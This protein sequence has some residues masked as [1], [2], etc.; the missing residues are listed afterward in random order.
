MTLRGQRFGQN[1]N[2][3][4]GKV[5]IDGHETAVLSWS[6]TEVLVGVPVSANPG[7]NREIVVVVAGVATSVQVRISC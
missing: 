7:N 4:D 3:V 2:A 1:R 5:R 6:M